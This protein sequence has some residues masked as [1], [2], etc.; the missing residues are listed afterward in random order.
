MGKR[1]SF[2]AI[3]NVLLGLALFSFWLF[4]FM[5]WL[6]MSSFERQRGMF[7]MNFGFIIYTVVILPLFIWLCTLSF[8]LWRGVKDENF[9]LVSKALSGTFLTYLVASIF[10]MPVLPLTLPI[11]IFAHLTR[12]KLL[13][14][15]QKGTN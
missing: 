6:S 5:E 15:T 13:E 10:M 8:R 7:D 3:F 2:L 1:I 4:V 9:S 11:A 14:T 12:K